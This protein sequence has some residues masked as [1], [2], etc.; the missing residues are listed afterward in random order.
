[1]VSDT[2]FDQ[3]A[4]LASLNASKAIAN[5]EDQVSSTPGNQETFTFST[6]VSG[7]YIL[8][9]KDGTYTSGDD[10]A[11]SLAEVQVWTTNSYCRK[12]GLSQGFNIIDPDGGD[13]SN[14]YEVFCDMS[15]ATNPREFISLPLKNNYNNFVFEDDSPSVQY[16]DEADNAIAS[17]SKNSFNFLQVIIDNSDI[18]VVPES[19]AEGSTNN[20]GYFSNINLIATPFAIDWANTTISHCDQNKLRIGSN[21]Q[22]V[23]INTLDYTN[24]RCKADDIRLKLLD[25]YTYLT[26]NDIVGTNGNVGGEVLEETCRQIFENLPDDS[27]HLPTGSSNGH[28]WIDP[29]LGGRDDTNDGNSV[30]SIF[31]P[32]VAYCKYQ[33]DIKQAWTFVMALD[34]KV[35]NTKDNIRTMDEVRANPSISHD[36]CSQ[37]GILFFVPNTKDTFTRTRQ[38][39][40]DNKPEWINYT[41]TIKEKYKMFMNKDNYYIAAEGYNE[42]WPYGPFGLYH[43][44]GGNKNIDNTYLDWYGGSRTKMAEGSGRCMNSGAA[45]GAENCTDYPQRLVQVP[46]DD[47]TLSAI[48]FRTTLR[49]LVEENNETGI[50][51][52]DQFWIADVGAGSHIHSG[53][54]NPEC[55]ITSPSSNDGTVGACNYIYYE[56]NG[57]YSAN[58]WLNFVAD[59][60]GNVYHLDDYNA[61]YPYYDYLC[62]SWDNYYSFGRYGLTSG[63]F[64]VIEKSDTVGNAKNSSIGTGTAV[65]AVDL[66]ITTKIVNKD[67]DFHAIIFDVNRTVVSKDSNISAGLFLVNIEVQTNNGLNSNIVTDE[68]YFGEIGPDTNGTVKYFGEVPTSGLIDLIDTTNYSALYP[69]NPNKITKAK[70]RLAFQYKYCVQDN[71]TWDACWNITGSGGDTKATCNHAIDPNQPGS[72]CKVAESNDFAVR[73]NNFTIA[74]LDGTLDGSTLVVKA[75]DVD[76]LYRANGFTGLSTQDYNVSFSNLNTDITLINLGGCAVTSLEDTNQSG[77]KFEDGLDTHPVILSDVGVY[78]FTLQETETQEFALVDQPDTTSTMRQISPNTVTLTV[79]PDHFRLSGFQ[80]PNFNTD[81]NFTYLSKPASVD[82][83][84][85][86]VD[87]NITAENHTNGITQNYINSCYASNVNLDIN[88]TV[89]VGEANSTIYY[90]I[91]EIGSEYNSSQSVSPTTGGHFIGSTETV[92][93]SVFTTT[94]V[95]GSAH[96]VVKFNFNRAVNVAKNPFTVNLNN[97]NVLDKS[98]AVVIETANQTVDQDATFVYGRV[99]GPK[100]ATYTNCI[101]N[102]TNC[103]SAD[104]SPRL[105]F[106]IYR[107]ATATTVPALNGATHDGTHDSRWWTSPFHDKTTTGK[108]G[109]ISTPANPHITEIIGTNAS[110]STIVVESNFRHRVELHYN[111]NDGYIKSGDFKH[112]PSSWLIYNKDDA[113]ATFNTFHHNFITEGWSGINESATTTTTKAANRTS[114]RIL[115]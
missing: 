106:Q 67:L 37:L 114:K 73:P 94:D 24:A 65:S 4:T 26:F 11:L 15:V 48:G 22:A 109:N 27:S 18:R 104:E 69:L 32:I 39:L 36:T 17:D 47:G 46:N 107:E 103:T 50:K 82:N 115:W 97:I 16:Y 30:D 40:K 61:N 21:D 99:A 70:S 20:E 31:R 77:F 90:K 33:P 58:A 62:M 8:I 93:K 41:G 72:D 63:P 28:Y 42:I 105:V 64:S 56:P 79:K 5:W 1:M 55:S 75:K 23:K 51:Y 60:E 76:I 19:V 9:Q 111:G 102:Q 34:A 38:Y 80:N 108:D 59:S 13:D 6:T 14:S 100:R 86:K 83:M 66:N 43:P 2:P 98:T 81:G 45:S 110:E 29:D 89:P 44:H 71:V 35:T 91:Y 113:T 12:N 87:F 54:T 25:D 7:Q 112:Y 53:N 78:N 84:A 101:D 3:N 10:K 49:D 74:S 57:N 95:N 68:W 85:A 92:A 96:I 88:F 52:G